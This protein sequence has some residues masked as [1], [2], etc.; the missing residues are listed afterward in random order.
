MGL[1]PS[2]DSIYN[3]RDPKD[4]VSNYDDKYDYEL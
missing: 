2:D 1:M 4:N 3:K